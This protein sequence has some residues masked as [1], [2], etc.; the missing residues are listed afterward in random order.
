LRIVISSQIVFMFTI[1]HETVILQGCQMV[2]LIE[3]TG[4]P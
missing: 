4:Q 3:K 1:Q 2:G